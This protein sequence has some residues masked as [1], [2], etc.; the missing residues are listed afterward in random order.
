MM[1]KINYLNNM[2]LYQ[3]GLIAN[4]FAQCIYASSYVNEAVIENAKTISDKHTYYY[5]TL[6]KKLKGSDYKITVLFDTADEH[7][8]LISYLAEMDITPLTLSGEM[9]EIPIL[10]KK[11][12]KKAQK[13]FNHIRNKELDRPRKERKFEKLINKFKRNKEDEYYET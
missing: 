5:C 11:E 7:S 12:I 2:D 9:I 10:D 3:S 1:E 6:L 8:L 13:S 4:T